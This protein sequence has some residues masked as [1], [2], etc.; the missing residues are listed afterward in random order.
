MCG[1]YGYIGSSKACQ[2]V[3][4]GLKAMEYRGYDSAGVAYF[5]DGVMRRAR[6]KGRVAGLEAQVAGVRADVAIGHTRWATHGSPLVKNAHPHR[7]GSITLVHNGIVENHQELKQ[8]LIDTHDVRFVSETDTEVLAALIDSFYLGDIALAVRRALQHVR[9]TF[10]ILVCADDIPD[11]VVVARRSSPVVIGHGVGRTLIASDAS[12]LAGKTRRITYLEDDQLAVCTKREVLIQNMLGASQP[13]VV[14][15]LALQPEELQKNGFDHFLLKE[16]H[17]QPEA[18]RSVL[19]GRINKKLMSAQLGGL[20]LSDA[21]IRSLQHIVITGCGT[22]YFA[23]LLAKQYFEQMTGIM[24]SVEQASELRYRNPVLPQHTLAIIVSQSGETADTLAATKE[25]KRRNIKTVGI[26]NVVGSTISREVDGGVYLHAGPEISVASTKAFT[27]QVVAMMLVATRIAEVRGA[28]TKRQRSEV[29]QAIEA[30]PIDI[31]HTLKLAPLVRQ[32]ASNWANYQHAFYLGRG[33]MY[34]IACEGSLKL[35]EVS[36]IHSEAYAAGEM[37]HGAI[38]L[39]DD[40]LLSV[41]LL[42]TGPLYE[43]SLSNLAEIQARGGAVLV[44]TNSKEF[45]KDHED[46]LYVRTRFDYSAPLVMNVALQLVAYFVAKERKC[47]IDQP[48]NLA[49]SVTVE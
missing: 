6:V 49:K 21:E 42:Q 10:G 32:R 5:Q 45:A 22:A 31:Q 46:A 3:V 44:V 27:T 8:R 38:A 41:F 9:G 15:E 26:V 19:R 47:A 17:D 35:K 40:S 25:L 23:G 29:L 24:V 4:D 14:D 43:K 7:S 28:L 48:R 18:V 37:K 11:T 30:L 16:I 34:P 39:V 12:A 13:L 36:Y 2:Y 1:I 33:T 20:N